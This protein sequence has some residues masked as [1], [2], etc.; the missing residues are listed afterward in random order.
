MILGACCVS[1]MAF[2]CAL[3]I[4]LNYA[5]LLSQA[6]SLDEL[7]GDGTYDMCGSINGI[8]DQGT[9]WTTVYKFNLAMYLIYSIV[10]GASIVCGPA[11]M[12]FFACLGCTGIPMLACFILTG[13]RILGSAGT[14][15]RDSTT[16]YK[17]DEDIPLTF[18]ADGELTRK[19]WISQLATN[20][21]MLCCGFAGINFSMMGWALLMGKEPPSGSFQFMQ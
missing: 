17:A 7:R 9:G 11:A 4:A 2:A 13:I 15:C 5:T 21:V 10:F 3:T 1:G 19:L 8:P 14:A 18:A 20:C 12:C 16:V 6:T